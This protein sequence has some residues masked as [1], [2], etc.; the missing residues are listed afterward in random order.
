MPKQK[1][2]K[3]A[4]EKR[5]IKNG[6]VAVAISRGFGAGWSTWEDISPFEP[7]V[8]E[9]ILSGKKDE[10]TEEWCKENLGKDIYTGGVDGLEVEWIPIGISF[11][12]NEYDGEESI[13]RSDE[14]QY[15]A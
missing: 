15:K 10:I 1:K 9:M 4:E 3:N 8:I 5:V 6:K 11:S 7:K 2:T 13:Y 14:L 12:I